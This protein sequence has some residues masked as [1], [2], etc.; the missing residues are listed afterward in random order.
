M[1]YRMTVMPERRRFGGGEKKGKRSALP[2]VV[3]ST[4]CCVAVLGGRH[5]LD[6]RG[7]DFT[8]R[9]NTKT[10]PKKTE[11]SAQKV[12]GSSRAGFRVYYSLDL[13]VPH[14]AA[15]GVCVGRVCAC[16]NVQD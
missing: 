3:V 16:V 10:K 11:R 1:G 13:K 15:A 2:P 5:I 8:G 6:G 9:E 14:E 12:A 4:Q 7:G